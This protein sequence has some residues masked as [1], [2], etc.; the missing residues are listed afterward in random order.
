MGL[1]PGVRDPVLDAIGRAGRTSRKH[2]GNISRNFHNSLR[3]S[4]AYLPVNVSMVPLVVRK[5]RPKVKEVK[6]PYPMISLKDWASFLLNHNHSEFLLGGFTVHDK[7]GY[8]QVFSTFWQRYQELDPDHEFFVQHPPQVWGRCLPYCLHGDE[9]RGKG[10]MPILIQSYQMVVGPDGVERTNT[11][12]IH[13][14]Y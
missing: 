8:T 1:N 11:S 7:R 4:G 9:G 5:L 14:I 6:I 2:Y 10:K 3:R 12:G 13:G